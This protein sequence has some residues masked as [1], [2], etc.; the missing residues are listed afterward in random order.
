MRPEAGRRLLALFAYLVPGA[1]WAQHITIDGSLG[2]AARTLAGPNY[3]ITASLGKQVGGNLVQSFGIFG[4]ATKEG[5]TF[6]PLML[7]YTAVSYTVFRGKV[8]PRTGHY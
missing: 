8:K 5:P 2:T 7:L 3:A 1:A 6:F 4:L